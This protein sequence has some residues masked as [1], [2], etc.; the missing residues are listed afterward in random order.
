MSDATPKVLDAVALLRDEP[1]L[2]LAR[3]QVGAVVEDLGE[4][5]FL[6]EFADAEGRTVAMPSVSAE[7][8]LVLSYDLV[9]AE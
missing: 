8:L 2:G 4:G 1:A 6:V 9:A 3:G 7:D 5:A